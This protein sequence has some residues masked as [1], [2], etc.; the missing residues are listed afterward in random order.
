M[1]TLYQ[2]VPAIFGSI[3]VLAFLFYLAI[4]YAH[5]GWWVLFMLVFPPMTIIVFTIAYWKDAKIPFLIL[6]S[7][8]FAIITFEHTFAKWDTGH[9]I[10][11]RDNTIRV[12]VP[13]SWTQNVDID[14]VSPIEVGERS[15]PHYLVVDVRPKSDVRVPLARFVE[16]FHAATE[17]VAS[18]PVKGK[19]GELDAYHFRLDAKMETAQV[20]HYFVVAEKGDRYYILEG[21]TPASRYDAALPVFESI[22][23]SVQVGG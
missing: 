2:V 7:C 1:A 10:A 9:V 3:A 6:A 8:V 13:S 21:W 14:G 22:A 16:Y 18:T 11:S 4:G 17:G 12:R 19:L 15:G 20:A 5:S 23:A